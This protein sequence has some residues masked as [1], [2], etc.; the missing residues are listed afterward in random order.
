[1]LGEPGFVEVELFRQFYLFEQFVER[2]LLGRPGPPLI[3]TEGAKSHLFAS[4]KVNF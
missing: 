2:L 1:M 3:V 4:L